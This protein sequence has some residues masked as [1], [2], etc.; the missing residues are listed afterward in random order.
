MVVILYGQ[1][2]VGRG[3]LQVWFF[4]PLGR[5]SKLPKTYGIFQ[6]L[7]VQAAVLQNL[8]TWMCVLLILILTCA[9]EM[10]IY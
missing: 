8:E 1:D 7:F 9:V 6:E 3:Y 5:D 4:Q 10:L 2:G